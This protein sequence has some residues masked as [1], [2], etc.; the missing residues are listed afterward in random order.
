VHA[1]LPMDHFTGM[2]IGVLW[3]CKIKIIGRL[4]HSFGK[5]VRDTELLN[6]PVYSQLLDCRHAAAVCGSEG[7]AAATVI[8][9]P[10]PSHACKPQHMDGHCVDSP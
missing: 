3:T 9:A 6:S 8:L 7:H 2:V 5:W 10:L 1:Q 4:Q